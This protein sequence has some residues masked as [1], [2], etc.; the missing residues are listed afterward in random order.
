MREYPCVSRAK[1]LDRIRYPKGLRSDWRCYIRIHGHV[2]FVGSYEA[3]NIAKDAF[4][5]EPSLTIR[6][7]SGELMLSNGR[8]SKRQK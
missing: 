8:H 2:C 4:I 5:I 7:R 6:T 1:Y 3:C